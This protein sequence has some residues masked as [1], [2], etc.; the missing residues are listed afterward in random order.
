[1]AHTRTGAVQLFPRPKVERPSNNVQPVFSQPNP[2]LTRAQAGPLTRTRQEVRRTADGVGSPAAPSIIPTITDAFGKPIPLETQAFN[3]L[4]EGRPVEAQQALR[5]A[6]GL[7]A[8][9]ELD[10]L[11]G[12]LAEVAKLLGPAVAS[13]PFLAPRAKEMLAKGRVP[14]L[15]DISP[16]F[17]RHTSPSIVQSLQGLLVG[18]GNLTREDVEFFSNTRPAS[19]R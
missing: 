1:M 16:A 14:L 7:P 5:R 12:S 4:Q 3:A 9:E 17:Y 19:F 10:V 15:E 8:D 6:A 13:N 18:T 2:F 11:E